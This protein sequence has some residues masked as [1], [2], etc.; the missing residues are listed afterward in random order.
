MNGR[1]ALDKV[2]ARLPGV[3]ENARPHEAANRGRRT[4]LP[5]RPAVEPAVCTEEFT[6]VGV[7]REPTDEERHGPRDP[8]RV[9][10]D[11]LLP[12]QTA[13]DLYFR[14]A[15]NEDRA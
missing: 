5:G 9:D 10:S 13:L 6:V 8:L 14:G 2:A 1:A 11:V 4:A 3:L 7:I 15:G 12:Y